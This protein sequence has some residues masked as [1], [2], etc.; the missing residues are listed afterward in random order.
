M[1]MTDSMGTPMKCVFVPMV[2]ATGMPMTNAMGVPMTMST[3]TSTIGKHASRT[4]AFRMYAPVLQVGLSVNY[5]NSDPS[6]CEI[7]LDYAGAKSNY[8]DPA[9][10]AEPVTTTT[11]TVTTTTYP[12]ETTITTE[13]TKT[14]T[15]RSN[16]ITT[17]KN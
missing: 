2:I 14:S 8:T 10:T 9:A 17:N 6:S 5:I 3:G 15:N 1:P 7:L 13:A 12:G 11:I 16:T 4:S